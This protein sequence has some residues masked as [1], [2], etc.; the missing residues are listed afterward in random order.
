[1]QSLSLFVPQLF[2]ED[3]EAEGNSPQTARMK[4]NE[5]KKDVRRIEGAL[6]GLGVPFKHEKV[7]T[8][9]TLTDAE[10]ESLRAL[11]PPALPSRCGLE[12]NPLA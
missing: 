8:S 9:A 12:L 11:L 10:A 1:M 6:E 4:L 5:R 7:G 3:L 2:L